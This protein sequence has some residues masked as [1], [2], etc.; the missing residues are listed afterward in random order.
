MRSSCTVPSTASVSFGTDFLRCHTTRCEIIS[1]FPFGAVGFPYSSVRCEGRMLHK[2][3]ENSSRKLVWVEG[4]SVA[5]WGC[6]ECTWVF[7]PPDMPTGRL[8][9]QWKLTCQMQLSEE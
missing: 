3:Q 8:L 9:D 4:R 6:S 5:G 7:N 1:S 2:D